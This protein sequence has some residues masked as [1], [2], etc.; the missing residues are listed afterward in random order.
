M[1]YKDPPPDEPFVK[2]HVSSIRKFSLALLT[3]NGAVALTILGSLGSVWDV[4]FVRSAMMSSGSFFALG[5]FAQRPLTVGT[6]NE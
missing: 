3:F 6:L 5:A 1:V 2:R 4:P